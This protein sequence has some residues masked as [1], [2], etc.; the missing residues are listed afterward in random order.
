LE[1]QMHIYI[2]IYI[3]IGCNDQIGVV[4]ISFSN[5]NKFFD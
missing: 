3:Y 5:V 2:Y 1:V 4:N